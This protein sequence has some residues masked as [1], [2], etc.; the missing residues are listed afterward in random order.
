LVCQQSSSGHYLAVLRNGN[1][2]RNVHHEVVGSVTR[3]YLSDS[4]NGY[5]EIPTDQIERFEPLVYQAAT[6]S[7]QRAAV[8]SRYVLKGDHEVTF[9][10][11]SYDRTKPLVIDPVLG[12]STYIGGSGDELSTPSGTDGIAVDPEGNAYIIGATSSIDFPVAPGALQTSFAGGSGS[13]GCPFN[14]HLRGR[15]RNEAQCAG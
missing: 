7:G 13:F 6:D 2:I 5:V 14:K 10:V 9:E 3:L 4:S 12:Y 1:S 15:F 11:A 8:D